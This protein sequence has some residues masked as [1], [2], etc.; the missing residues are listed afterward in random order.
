M[1][2]FG[3]RSSPRRA[4]SF[5]NLRGSQQKWQNIMVHWDAS[6][7]KVLHKV[8][9]AHQLRSHKQPSRTA[10][11]MLPMM[12]SWRAKKTIMPTTKPSAV[13]LPNYRGFPHVTG[14]N[15]FAVGKG[16]MVVSDQFYCHKIWV[17]SPEQGSEKTNCFEFSSATCFTTAK[18]HFN[19]RWHCSQIAPIF[20]SLRF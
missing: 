15:L 1:L 18:T 13:D 6:L 3:R 5:Q 9:I 12:A 16:F 14:E 11:K 7:N 20:W 2:R 19:P 10:G 8:H 17:R 4:S